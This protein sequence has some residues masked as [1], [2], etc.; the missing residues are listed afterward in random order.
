[1]KPYK[2]NTEKENCSP[3][4]S[5]CVI[6][7]GPDLPCINLCKGDTVSDVVY[8]LADEVCTL[9]DSIGLSDVDL[10]CLLQ[11]CSTTPEPVKTLTN[12]L[13]LLVSKVCCLN[14][15]VINLP[16][17]GNNYTE[18]ILNLPAC[19]Q[20]SDGMG[21]TVTQL[22]HHDYTLR[23][24]TFLCA[25]YT[26]VNTHTGQIA[27]LQQ[28]VHDLENPTVVVPEISSCLLGTLE[29]V[30]VVLTE[31]E[32]QFCDYKVVLGE[33]SDI[34]TAIGKQCTG[35]TGATPALSTGTP[36][37]VVF[38]GWKNT[39]QT[40]ADSLTNLWF[41]VCDIRS[42]VKIIQTNCCQVSCNDIV[43]DFSYKWIDSTTLRL[44]FFQKT[45][46]P[47]GFWDCDQLTGTLFTLTDAIGNVGEPVFITFRK[48][49]PL[50][51]TGLLDDITIVP[52]QSFDI[53]GLGSSTSALDIT[54]GLT[55]TAEPCFTNGETNC[56]KCV[57]KTIGGYVN[58]ECCTITAT[59]VVTIIYKY[60]FTETATTTTTTLLGLARPVVTA[61]IVETTTILED[62]TTTTT[63]I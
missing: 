16:P 47:L 31:L 43:I 21:G 9:K 42:A 7:Q 46:V 6:W 49:N 61:P 3:I 55:I 4:S 62:V 1:M 19:L 40:L 13:D 48:E 41:T 20:Y 27:S 39:V 50:D 37:A 2:S 11:V 57:N 32:S 30:E 53:T 5:N 60:C 29:T 45:T 14:D 36:M 22:I 17:A 15:I 56:V 63:I 28:A 51:L 52:F 54:T 25:L 10:T 26:T 44:F 35:L 8:K 34:N 18:P 12:I 38:P 58:T 24:A 59:G 23:I 33:P